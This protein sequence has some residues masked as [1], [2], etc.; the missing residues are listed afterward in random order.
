M[1]RFYFDGQAPD[2]LARLDAE[3][4]KHAVQVLRLRENESIVLLDGKGRVYS[5]RI[6]EANAACVTARVEEELPNREAGVRITLYQGM[7]K[8]D[9]MEWIIQKCTELGVT[10]FCPVMFS[11]CVKEMGKNPEKILNRWSRIAR[12]A[13]KQCGRGLVPEILPPISMKEME[14]RISG[15]EK[16]LIAWEDAEGTR[17]PTWRSL[18]ALKADWMNR[19]LNA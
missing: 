10:T 14:K 13:A 11:R 4:S 3:E 7:P 19:K 15:H 5:A 8:A 18:S 9:K 16:A 17:L 2:G 12:E 1:H 6:E